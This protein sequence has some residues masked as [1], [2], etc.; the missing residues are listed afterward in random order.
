LFLCFFCFFFLLSSSKVRSSIAPII[1]ILH[2]C[3]TFLTKY[4]GVSLI[5]LKCIYNFLCSMLVFA[6]FA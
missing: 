4:Q 1:V 2:M 5:R 3:S 6:P